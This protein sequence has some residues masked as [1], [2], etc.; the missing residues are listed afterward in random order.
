MRAWRMIPQIAGCASRS[1]ACSVRNP[2][3]RPAFAELLREPAVADPATM[4]D[5]VDETSGTDRVYRDTDRCKLCVPTKARLFSRLGRDERLPNLA[6]VLL[7]EVKERV[8][9]RRAGYKVLHRSEE[10]EWQP[11]GDVSWQVRVAGVHEVPP[12]SLHLAGKLLLVC[13]ERRTE[14]EQELQFRRVLRCAREAEH[15]VGGLDH[16]AEAH[17]GR[18]IGIVELIAEDRHKKRKVN[19]GIRSVAGKHQVCEDLRERLIG[20]GRMSG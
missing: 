18:R 3:L 13:A 11:E 15:V 17:R 5:R 4:D 2:A 9:N 19:A 6:E 1:R 12:V 8:R 20:A 14:I 16:R 7:S 10:V